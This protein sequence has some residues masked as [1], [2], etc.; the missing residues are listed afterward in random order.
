LALQE[1][2]VDQVYVDDGSIDED[3]AEDEVNIN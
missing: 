3:Y 1:G 2:D